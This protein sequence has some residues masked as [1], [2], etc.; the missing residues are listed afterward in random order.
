MPIFSRGFALSLLVLALVQAGS[1]SAS[2]AQKA[3]VSHGKSAVT[4]FDVRQAVNVQVPENSQFNFYA[5]EKKL[6]DFVGSM[7]VRAKLAERGA[8]RAL[9]AEQQWKVDEA[10]RRV[11]SQIEIEHVLQERGEPDDLE[12]F[13]REVYIASPE[14]FTE[15]PAVHAQHVLISTQERSEEEA[16][17]LARSVWKKAREGASFEALALEYSEDR[18]AQKNKGDLG[19]FS[20]GRMVKP[21]EDAAFAMK[22][23]GDIT[24]PVKTQFGYHVIRLVEKR[25]ERLRP[26]DEVKATLIAEERSRHRERV[27]NELIDDVGSLEGVN[28]NNEALESLMRRRSDLKSVPVR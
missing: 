23:P 21:F 19:F 24:E 15:P 13:A 25:G 16:L 2:D 4:V 14:R 22:K 1:A 8:Q 26:F 27:V 17:E 11:Y 28:V 12:D 3:I 20:S 10:L 18:S 6:R 7:F 9:T 5:D